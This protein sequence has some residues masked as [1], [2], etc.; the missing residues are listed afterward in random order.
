[1]L[2]NGLFYIKK[3]NIYTH[4]KLTQDTEKVCVL[5]RKINALKYFNFP[6]VLDFMSILV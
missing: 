5:Y 4:S 3:E 2:T 6:P 1:M